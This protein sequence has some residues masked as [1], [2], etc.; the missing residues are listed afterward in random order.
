MLSLTQQAIVL[1]GRRSRREP[2]RRNLH[3]QASLASA[4][5]SAGVYVLAGTPAGGSYPSKFPYANTSAPNDVTSN[6]NGTCAPSYFCT[7][8]TGYDGPTGWGTPNGVG[9]FTG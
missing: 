8:R 5:I 1:A 4:P 2:Y 9:A 6:G 3:P 7:A